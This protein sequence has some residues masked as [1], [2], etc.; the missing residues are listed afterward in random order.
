MGLAWG[1][2][3]RPPPASSHYYH[4]RIFDSAAGSGEIQQVARTF[5]FEVRGLSVGVAQTLVV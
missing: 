2:P 5:G 4:Y 3:E 1:A